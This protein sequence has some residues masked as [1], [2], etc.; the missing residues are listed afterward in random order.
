MKALFRLCHYENDNNNDCGEDTST[1]GYPWD[2][3]AG[4]FD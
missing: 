3:P 1:Y 2:I 4:P